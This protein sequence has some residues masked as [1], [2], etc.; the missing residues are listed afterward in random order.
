LMD[1]KLK[2][3]EVNLDEADIQLEKLKSGKT[4]YEMSS[5]DKKA[6]S[7][8]STSDTSV[9]TTSE[10]DAQSNPWAVEVEGVAINHARFAMIDKSTNS[11]T[12]IKDLTFS[13][14]D[15]QFDAWSPF[16]FN[17]TGSLN[18]QT[19]GLEGKGKFKV[20]QQVKNYALKDVELS[21][22]Y[23]TPDLNIDEATLG[24]ASF[25]LGKPSPVQMNVSMKGDGVAG[26]IQ[27]QTTLSIDSAFDVI[28]LSGLALKGD[29]SG[30]TLPT[31]KL[32]V[33]LNSDISFN[34][35]AKKVSV[36]IPQLL[37]N[38]MSLDGQMN[39][40]LGDIPKVRFDF[41]SNKL[42][43][44]SLLG[45]KDGA[46]QASTGAKEVT[47]SGSTTKVAEKEPDLS[48]LKQL[49]IAGSLRVDKFKASNIELSN[50]T[51]AMQINDGKATLSKF[52]ADLYDGTI[53]AKA[54]LN[55][56]KA[57][58]AYSLDADIKSV[59]V[60][61][62]LVA[63]ADNDILEGTGDITASITG[64][65]LISDKLMKNLLGTIQ[66]K[67]S[68]GAINGIN[69]PQM[70]RVNY[71]KFKGETLSEEDTV[72]KT[73][74]SSLTS[75]INLKGGVA[76]TSNLAMSSPLLR[77]HGEG[78]ANYIEKTTD[79]LVR[80]SVVKSLEG[81]GGKS[82]DELRDVTIPIKVT[83][84]WEKPK[85]R[86]VFD[87]VLKQKANKELDR[88]LEKLDGKIKDEKTKEAVNSLLKGL[89]K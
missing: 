66:V 45:Q 81:Q 59:Q 64:S 46:G 62:L 84:P 74:F 88:G 24:I 42:D 3:G 6:T 20:D 39:A 12:A 87:D 82:I 22:N 86:L 34:N 73:D 44:D 32:K 10:S 48:I 30:N 16:S 56:T 7:E 19:F 52:G 77:I 89:L 50:I 75:T 29:L 40:V 5:S 41:H 78:S 8:V 51:T 55:G 70:I 11:T 26:K 54:V 13:V 21:A 83:G 38:D 71:A 47:G 4:N 18:D 49:D 69:V 35:L 31:N 85:Y 61:P 25:E 68:D 27:G 57:T 33:D 43:V 53:T 15:F 58:P 63:A 1:N 28:R 9:N 17:V 80:T 14:R 76:S 67:F 72:K 65:S 79:F 36:T 60:Q 2:I 37:V 23:N